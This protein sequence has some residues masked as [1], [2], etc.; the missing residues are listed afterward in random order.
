HLFDAGVAL[1]RQRGERLALPDRPDHGRLAAGRDV[2]VRTGLGEP[3]DYVVDLLLGRVRAHD[4]QELG[5]S[6]DGHPTQDRCQAGTTSRADRRGTRPTRTVRSASNLRGA[7]NALP[8]GA[9]QTPRP[10][11]TPG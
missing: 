6:R 3:L 10:V 4:D 2:R 7:S 1:E 5:G 8:S 9:R 11:W